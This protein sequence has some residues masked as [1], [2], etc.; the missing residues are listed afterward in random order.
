MSVIRPDQFVRPEPPGRP[1]AMTFA[2]LAERLL[3]GPFR[4]LL[5]LHARA[6]TL[7]T[8]AEDGDLE[9]L[10]K[11]VELAQLARMA[12]AQLNDFTL[13]LQSLIDHLAP[14]NRKAR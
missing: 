8:V 13:E 9:R 12:T 14:E 4:T 11:L 6:G 1:A 3:E 7:A 5:T 10:Q 2:S